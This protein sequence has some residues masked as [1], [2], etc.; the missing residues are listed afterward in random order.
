NP[1]CLEKWIK[2]TQ[3]RNKSKG[4]VKSKTD[5]SCAC[6]NQYIKEGETDGLRGCSERYE[7]YAMAYFNL[8]DICIREAKIASKSAICFTKKANMINDE[9]E[10]PT[11]NW[12]ETSKALG[13]NWYGHQE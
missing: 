13:Y 9:Q 8:A 12:V 11:G 10:Q 1:S 3:N 4:T 2:R 6:F 5:Q 7:N